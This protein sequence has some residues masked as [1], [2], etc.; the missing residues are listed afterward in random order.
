MKKSRYFLNAKRDNKN[1]DLL[2]GFEDFIK[3]LLNLDYS[4]GGTFLIRNEN[5]CEIC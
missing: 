1:I 3:Q 4:F 2:N 5:S